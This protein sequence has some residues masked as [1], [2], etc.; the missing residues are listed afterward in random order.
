MFVTKKL[1]KLYN[2][3]CSTS[4]QKDRDY[5]KLIKRINGCQNDYCRDWSRCLISPCSS[6][7]DNHFY[8]YIWL[9]WHF[10]VGRGKGGR[11]GG[12]N[13]L[14]PVPFN[15][16]SHLFGF[17]ECKILWNPCYV[18]ILFL[19]SSAFRHL[20]NPASRTPT[21]PPFLLGFHLCAPPPHLWPRVKERKK[22][23]RE[24][25]ENLKKD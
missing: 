5:S 7:F 12:S 20:E 6:H 3:P 10:R 24:E 1:P 19:I 9:F 4:G 8:R 11:G 21:P 25:T 16:G 22:E 14:P 15:I 17:F 18:Y 2:Q 23:G 13:L